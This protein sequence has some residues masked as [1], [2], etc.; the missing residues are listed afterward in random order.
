[1]LHEDIISLYSENH[2]YHAF[3]VCEKKNLSYNLL[4]LIVMVCT[5]TTGV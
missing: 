5:M 4:A 1:M 3:T 2:I